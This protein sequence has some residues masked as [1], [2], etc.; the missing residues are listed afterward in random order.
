VMALGFRGTQRP[1]YMRSKS[2]LFAIMACLP[3]YRKKPSEKSW[4]R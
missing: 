3:I 1:T 4:S 2:L